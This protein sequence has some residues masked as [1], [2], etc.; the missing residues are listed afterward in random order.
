MPH[1]CETNDADI[2]Y[3][4]GISKREPAEGVKGIRDKRKQQIKGDFE[5]IALCNVGGEFMS[6][7]YIERVRQISSQT[8][9]RNID[10][11]LGLSP[12]EENEVSKYPSQTPRCRF[13]QTYAHQWCIP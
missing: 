5:F 3:W 8:W 2:D 9:V 7:K 13:I 6:D 4:Q 11:R 10:D 12:S 1:Y